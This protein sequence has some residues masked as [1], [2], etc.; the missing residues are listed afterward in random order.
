MLRTNIR[1]Y[2]DSDS[3]FF[4]ERMASFNSRMKNTF[5]RTST[6]IFCVTDSGKNKEVW[7]RYIPD[8]QGV[9]IKLAHSIIAKHLSSIQISSSHISSNL[10]CCRNVN[11]IDRPLKIPFND[12]VNANPLKRRT[13]L[14]YTK[15]NDFEFEQEWRFVIHECINQS[16]KFPEDMVVKVILAPYVTDKQF[17]DIE[18]WNSQRNRPFTISQLLV[19]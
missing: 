4:K 14:L 16:I 8:G 7:E 19:E 9:C 18:D 3:P 2:K 12:Y 10:L 15:L 17:Q 6:C 1:Q 13:T 5:E 11:Y